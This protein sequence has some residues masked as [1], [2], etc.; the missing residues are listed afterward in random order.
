MKYLLGFG[1]ENFDRSDW[2]FRMFV[3]KSDLVLA[4][5]AHLRSIYIFD[6]ALSLLLEMHGEKL[7]PSARYLPESGPLNSQ[8]RLA[9]LPL[10][11]EY[12]TV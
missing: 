7:P 11:S 1:E 12:D 10:G 5:E 3:E 9:V 2:T 4:F 6:L 8:I